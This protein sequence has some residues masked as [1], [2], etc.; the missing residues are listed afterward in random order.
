M[1]VSATM[2]ELN[3]Y[4]LLHE[5]TARVYVTPPSGMLPT[6]REA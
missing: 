2:L 3:A 4:R 5:V 6:Y 1:I